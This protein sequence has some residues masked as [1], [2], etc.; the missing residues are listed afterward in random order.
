MSLA[1]SSRSGLDSNDVTTDRKSSVRSTQHSNTILIQLVVAP[2]PLFSNFQVCFVVSVFCL[3]CPMSTTKGGRHESALCSIIESIPLL[4]KQLYLQH[5][6]LELLNAF[7]DNFLDKWSQLIPVF[8]QIREDSLGYTKDLATRKRRKSN[9]ITKVSVFLTFAS[10][11]GI[12]N[13][14]W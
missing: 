6:T 9:Q 3:T 13:K 10:Q 8:R 5:T 12:V 14:P 2:F 1:G 4:L 11:R 7:P